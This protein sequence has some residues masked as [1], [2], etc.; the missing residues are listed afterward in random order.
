MRPA[1]MKCK[2]NGGNGA[3]R[4]ER[5]RLTRPQLQLKRNGQAMAFV[6]QSI[7]PANHRFG[8]PPALVL[9]LNIV[10]NLTNHIAGE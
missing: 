1:A 6:T 2:E 7:G 5:L 8:L 3:T 10:I 4:Y 9:C